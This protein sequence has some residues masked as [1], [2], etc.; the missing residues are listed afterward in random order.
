MSTTYFIFIDGIG[1]GPDDPAINPLGKYSLPAFHRLAGNQKL[2]A[3]ARKVN[4]PELQF[5]GIDANLDVEGLPQSGTGQ[6]TLFTGVN[7]SKLAGKHFGPYPH[8]TSHDTIDRLNVFSRLINSGVGTVDT[9]AFA[10]C[11]PARFF[12]F[13]KK[14]SRWTVTTRCTVAANLRIRAIDDLNSGDG[15]AADITGEDL[16]RIEPDAKVRSESEAASNLLGL[17]ASNRLV[18][19]EY[20]HTD[21]AGHSQ[22]FDRAEKRLSSL[23]R[24][25]DAL[26]KDFDTSRDVIVITSDHGN[27]EDLSTKSHT[28][29]PVPL[30]AY[31]KNAAHFA[32]V[33]DL[34][35]V[36]P[37]IV[38]WYR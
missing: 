23:D 37:A 26:L 5:H 3:S 33:R 12:D 8:S 36:T 20:F 22:S 14:T 25:F 4:R 29:N 24:F 7:C 1:I 30:I 13:A 28:R 19:F 21:K 11:Y 10:N 15:L 9:L 16:V 38:D 31:G 34:T 2:T 17:G 18:L 32:S 27:I 35:D 6:A